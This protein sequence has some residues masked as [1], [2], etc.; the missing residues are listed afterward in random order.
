MTTSTF[1]RQ[2]EVSGIARLF[3]E[4]ERGSADL[5]PLLP[6]L[7]QIVFVAVLLACVFLAS[8]LVA[9]EE[10]QGVAAKPAAEKPDLTEE[11]LAAIAAEPQGRK[12]VPIGKGLEGCRI[13]ESG[14]TEAIRITGTHNGNAKALLQKYDYDPNQWVPLSPKEV[15]L[16][17][18]WRTVPT[19]TGKKHY[20]CRQELRLSPHAIDRQGASAQEASAQQG[21]ASRHL[22][23]EHASPAG[24][25]EK[26]R[27]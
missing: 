1:N 7:V 13:L 10:R 4:E 17:G 12:A 20:V 2:S 14:G 9:E 8:P 27:P 6:R 5:P 15:L 19:K 16:L 18:E 21:I 25:P 11:E 26:P 23:A 22:S 3:L 24:A